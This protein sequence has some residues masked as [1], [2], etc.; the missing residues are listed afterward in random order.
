MDTNPVS[1]ADLAG[2]LEQIARRLHSQGYASQ[3][4]PAQWAA[5]RYVQSAP[6]HMRTAIDLARFQGLASGAVAR[7]VRTLITKG[8]LAKL[9]T[10]GRGRAEQLDLTDRGVTLLKK[11]PLQSIAAA[12]EPLSETE[13]QILAKGLDMAIRSTMA[14]DRPDAS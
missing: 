3:L 5:L 10:I 12:L 6:P 11:D 14:G 1:T 13:R 7:T 9:G 2:L 8:Y 4:F